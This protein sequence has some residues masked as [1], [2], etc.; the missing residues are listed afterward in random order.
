[1]VVAAFLVFVVRIFLG[2]LDMWDSHFFACTRSAIVIL[3]AVWGSSLKVSPSG[4]SSVNET[5]WEIS[6]RVLT[7]KAPIRLMTT[8]MILTS[9]FR[10]P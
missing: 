5:S 3:L 6:T 9:A 8:G 2:I 10:V 7:W 4:G 1:V